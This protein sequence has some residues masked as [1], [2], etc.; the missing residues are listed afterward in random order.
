MCFVIMSP[1]RNS[2]GFIL[3]GN[4]Y[5]FMRTLFNVPTKRGRIWSAHSVR[6]IPI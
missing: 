3:S 5:C 6:H 2:A 1:A 4:I